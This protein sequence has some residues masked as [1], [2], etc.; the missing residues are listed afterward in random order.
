MTGGFH[1]CGDER[2]S[3]AAG[4]EPPS[5]GAPQG[6]AGS[7][8]FLGGEAPPVRG[9]GGALS[10]FYLTSTWK[11]CGATV[12]P[13]YTVKKHLNIRLYDYLDARRFHRPQTVAN[14]NNVLTIIILKDRGHWCRRCSSIR[15]GHTSTRRMC[16]SVS[17]SGGTKQPTTSSALRETRGSEVEVAAVTTSAA[18]KAKSVPGSNTSSSVTGRRNR[19]DVAANV[20]VRDDG[21]TLQRQQEQT[22]PRHTSMSSSNNCLHLPKLH[23]HRRSHTCCEKGSGNLAW[24]SSRATIPPPAATPS[25]IRN[26]AIC[27]GNA[28]SHSP[29]RHPG[30]VSS[31]GSTIGEY[32][33][34]LL[35][36]R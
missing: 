19:H 31:L 4:G 14:K 24:K 30:F 29:I 25:S 28:G 9:G 12:Q 33:K 32:E 2:W 10:F 1:C 15:P 16:F 22:Q 35:F 3:C 17:S 18:T 21:D 5:P 13:V 11:L 7:P 8:L 26:Q 34:H 6:K 20:I 36:E 27:Y 23:H